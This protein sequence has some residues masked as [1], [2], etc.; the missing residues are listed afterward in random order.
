MKSFTCALEHFESQITSL[1]DGNDPLRE[2]C[3]VVR[4]ADLF[5]VDQNDKV[6]LK[7][8]FFS[9]VS[10]THKGPQAAATEGQRLPVK[11]SDLW[12]SIGV[13]FFLLLLFC[14]EHHG[15][16][17]NFDGISGREVAASF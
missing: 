17:I 4:K 11:T 3:G 16:F 9:P 12:F 14:M 5:F 1:Q 10:V 7:I 6:E 8:E 15:M 13:G 2:S